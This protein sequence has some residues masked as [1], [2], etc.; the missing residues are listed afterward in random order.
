LI[1]IDDIPI[2]DA[3]YFGFE[4]FAVMEFVPEIDG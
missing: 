1:V 3:S 4:C 2:L